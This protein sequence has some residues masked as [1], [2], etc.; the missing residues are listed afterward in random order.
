MKQLKHR[1]FYKN[2]E[3]KATGEFQ[4]LHHEQ[5]MNT[6]FGN[7]LNVE[8]LFHLNS[9]STGIYYNEMVLDGQLLNKQN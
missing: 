4:D 2:R 6:V 7:D 1:K 5:L 8:F 3:N 9:W